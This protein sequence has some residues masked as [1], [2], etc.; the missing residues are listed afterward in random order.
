MQTN[1][2]AKINKKLPAVQRVTCGIL[3]HKLAS[4]KKNYT[5]SKI[6]RKLLG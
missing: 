5:H 2:K 1:T 6:E 3:Y 4:R